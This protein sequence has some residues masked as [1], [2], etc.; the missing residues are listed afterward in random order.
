MT[1]YFYGIYFNS[2]IVLRFSIEKSSEKFHLYSV[3]NITYFCDK[4][5]MKFYDNSLKDIGNM[6]L[7]CKNCHQ[8]IFVSIL[9]LLK[10]KKCVTTVTL[11]VSRKK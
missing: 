3:T 11:K 7:G 9:Y 5:G 6:K 2:F 10:R 4:F 1:I 8:E